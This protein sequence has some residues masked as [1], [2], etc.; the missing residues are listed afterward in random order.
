MLEKIISIEDIIDVSENGINIKIIQ[1]P[2]IKSY[3]MNVGK[4]GSNMLIKVV[5]RIGMEI[6]Q[7]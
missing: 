7:E 3:L 5:L 2:Q 1:V 4:T 6:L